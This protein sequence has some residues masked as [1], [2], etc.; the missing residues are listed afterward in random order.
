MP[1]QRDWHI[2]FDEEQYV[3]QADGSL[4]GLLSRPS[5]RADWEAALADAR[6]LIEPTAMWE[7]FPIRE[8]RH[9]RLVLADGTRIGSG[10]VAT[11]VAGATELVVGVCTVGSAISQRISEQLRGG[12]RLHAWFLD[13]LGSWAVDQV[14]QQLCRQIESDAA[15][16][17]WRASASLSPGESEWSV[18]EQA[19]LFSL[20][21]TRAIG[22][23]LNESMVMSPVK[24]LSLIVGIG[25]G[26]LGV[27]GASNC[28]FCTIRERCS[29]R[30]RRLTSSLPTHSLQEQN[31]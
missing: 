12:R 13:E 24:S 4:P 8:F 20:L 27:E 9:E 11:V 25:P 21:D 14:R 7:S 10:P 15:S 29:Y 17:G 5:V 1:I 19:V 28:D 23:T 30:Q 16:R 31:S 26:P 6:D 22:V 2:E 3:A 18:A